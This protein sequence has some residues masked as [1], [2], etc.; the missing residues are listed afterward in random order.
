VET[1]RVVA[2]ASRT[3][4]P[5]EHDPCLDATPPAA[6]IFKIVTTAALLEEAGIGPDEA[7]C[8]RTGAG[9][10]RL[11]L[12]DVTE[13]TSAPGDGIT[14]TT[15]SEA[16]AKSINPVYARLADGRLSPRVL[17]RFAE[18]FAFGRAIPFELP[19]DVS[20][21][22]IPQDRLEFARTASG[23]WHVGL[24]PLHAAT[25]AQLVANGGEMLQPTLIDSV[26]AADGTVLHA[27]APRV[28]RRVISP[29]T[30]AAIERMMQETVTTGTGKRDFHDP[31]GE[32]FVAVAVAGKTGSLTQPK[33]YMAYSWF[34]GYAPA[35]DVAP[36]TPRYAVA[37][38]VVNEERWRIKGTFLAREALRQLL[39]P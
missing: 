29:E 10:S 31:K 36:G 1:G 6:S 14:C 35:G 2:M 28:L 39:A 30:A 5:V 19:A 34:V 33:P 13:E 23:F 17:L 24:S 18:R 11:T 20:P 3:R 21:V 37:A 27:T 12:R 7:I 8:H 9:R 32:P 38:L 22:E 4:G 25:M 15:L 26:L 16:L